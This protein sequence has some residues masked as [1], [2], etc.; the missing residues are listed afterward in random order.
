VAATD[1]L[2]ALR[3][4]RATKARVAGVPPHVILDDRTLQVV[5]E[6]RPTGRAQLAALPGL[7]PTKLARYGDELLGIVTGATGSA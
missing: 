4:W 5:A 1:A 2:S 3:R 7:R 6:H